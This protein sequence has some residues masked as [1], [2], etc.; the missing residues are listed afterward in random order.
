MDD[1]NN[2]GRLKIVAGANY[3]M[4]M[5]NEFDRITGYTYCD[6]GSRASSYDLTSCSPC[7]EGTHSIDMGSDEC[8]SCDSELSGEE[9]IKKIKFLCV[10]ES[11]SRSI[12]LILAVIVLCVGSCCMGTLMMVICKKKKYC[13][14]S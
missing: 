10:E 8:H 12:A 1:N 7:Q 13:C 14:F 3:L 4:L 9:R 11:S 5:H 2:K 6:Y